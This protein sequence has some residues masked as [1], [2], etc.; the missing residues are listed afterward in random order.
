MNKTRLLT[1][2]GSATFTAWFFSSVA[3]T[4]ELAPKTADRLIE[5]IIVDRVRQRLHKAGGS[6]DRIAKT[7]LLSAE[8]IKDRQAANLTEAIQSARGQGIQ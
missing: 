3:L 1:A 5:S 4:Q 6:K 8:Q 7:E 2:L